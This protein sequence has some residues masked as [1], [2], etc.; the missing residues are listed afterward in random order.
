[1]TVINPPHNIEAEQALLS[2]ILVKPEIVDDLPDLRAEHFYAPVHQRIYEA[3]TAKEGGAE[4]LRHIFDTDAELLERGGG[5]YLID[6]KASVVTTV[7][8]PHYAKTLQDL[9]NRRR[10]IEA[11]QELVV[12]AAEDYEADITAEA[13]KLLTGFGEKS[14]ATY[15]AAQAVTSAIALMDEIRKGR[16]GIRTGIPALDEKLGGLYPGCLY[17]I[18]A[19]PGMGKT[20]LAL[21]MADNISAETDVLFHSLEMPADELAM[22]MIAAR[23]GVPVGIQRSDRVL[24]RSQMDA[25]MQAQGDVQERRLVVDDQAGIGVQR[26]IAGARRFKRK[27]GRFALFIDY[28]GLIAGDRKIQNRV[29]QIEQITTGL[30]TLAKELSIPVVLLSQL[31]RT[32]EQRTDKRPGLSD[33]RDSGSIEQDADVVMFVYRDDYYQRETSL[34][35][36]Q[37]PKVQ[38]GAEILIEKNRQGERGTVL[39]SFD[40]ARQRFA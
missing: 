24:H 38:G 39:L 13:E 7:G 40:G 28:L 26:I 9:F 3:V 37:A 29:H 14:A 33:L 6:L 1:M 18:A 30:K 8:A 15:T 32:V 21:N 22:R 2:A 25:I 12:M 31:N 17:I 16:G 10:M 4:G 23:S 5:Q 36:P 11:A 27:H 19:R 34:L 20:A 35:M